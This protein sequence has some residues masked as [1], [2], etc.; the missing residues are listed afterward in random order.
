M[1]QVT[2][3]PPHLEYFERLLSLDR[4]GALKLVDRFLSEHDNDV[5]VLYSKVLVPALIHTGEQW[6]E[7][8]ISVAH[9]HYISE[10]TRDLILRYGPRLWADRSNYLGTAVACCTR[11][12][13]MSS[14]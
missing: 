6:L 1:N 14:V 13:A 8:R 10:V 3:T 2:E 12:N 9:E 5:A 11:T 7:D 4:S